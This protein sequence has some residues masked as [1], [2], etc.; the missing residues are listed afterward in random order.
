MD[1]IQQWGLGLILALQSGLPGL[2]GLMRAFSF[3]GSEEFFLLAMPVLYWCVSAPLGVRIAVLLIT[4]DAVNGF[5]KLAFH[6][7]RPYWVDERVQALAVETSYGLPSG[8]AQTAVAV[9]GGLAV[10]LKRPWVWVTALV[11]IALISFSRIYLGVHFPSDVV[12]GWLIGALLVWAFAKWESAL[13]ARLRALNLW[14][15]IGLALAVSLI[16]L[17]LVSGA[18]L[19]TAATPDPSQWGLT[20]AQATQTPPGEAA[21]NPRDPESPVS[22]AGRLFGLGASLALMAHTAHARFNAGGPWVKRGARFLVG[23][24][25]VLIFW[26]GLKAIFPEGTS[27]VALTLRF[28][29]YALIVLWA[30]Y[31]APWVFVRLRLAEAG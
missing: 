22:A 20:A 8:H 21:L 5:F 26:L 25:G 3:L 17:A 9:W 31:F 10:Q 6:L 14:V 2:A 12:A 29:R 23:V 1:A 13:V 7:P 16:Y 27:A 11:I 28:V 18:L 19:M 4:S 30:L 24:V 15:L